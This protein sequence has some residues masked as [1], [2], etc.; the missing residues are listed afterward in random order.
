MTWVSETPQNL[1]ER[2]GVRLQISDGVIERDPALFEEGLRLPIIEPQ[3]LTDLAMRKTPCAIA[4]DHGVLDHV[5]TDRL[6]GIPPLAGHGIGHADYNV[7]VWML[8]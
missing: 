8:A 6:G 3:G 2:H 5:P 4:L 1:L 7:H